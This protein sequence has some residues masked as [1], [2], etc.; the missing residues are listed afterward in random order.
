MFP[1]GPLCVPGSNGA[2]IGPDGPIC[3]SAVLLE[4]PAFISPAMSVF[5]C[6]ASLA[7][8]SDNLKSRS[9]CTFFAAAVLFA[10]SFCNAIFPSRP[11]SSVAFRMSSFLSACSLSALILSRAKSCFLSFSANSSSMACFLS[12]SRSSSFSFNSRLRSNRFCL[13]LF[14]ISIWSS[15]GKESPNV[16]FCGNTTV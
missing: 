8:R 7:L 2:S 15:F 11:L 14:I 4:S 1:Y 16:F 5:F 12:C 3:G 6:C 9:N 13:M 10:A